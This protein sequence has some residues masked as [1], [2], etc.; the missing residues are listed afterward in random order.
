MRL[1]VPACLPVLISGV[2]CAT[3]SRPRM[4]L[5]ALVKQSDII[6]SGRVVRTLGGDG[7]REQVHP[8]R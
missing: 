5:E 8:C 2:L 3:D 6:V 4:S 7:R 1:R